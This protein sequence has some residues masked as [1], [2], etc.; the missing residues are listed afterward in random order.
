MNPDF[1][2]LLSSNTIVYDGGGFIYLD[3]GS[4]LTY[5]QWLIGLARAL[6]FEYRFAQSEDMQQIN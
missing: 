1:A 2:Y 4:V 5:P 3:K 6:P